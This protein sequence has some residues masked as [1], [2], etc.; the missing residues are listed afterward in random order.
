MNYSKIPKDINKMIVGGQ[1]AGSVLEKLIAKTK[2]GTNVLELED[3]A[4]RLITETGAE[5][6]FKRVKGYHHA[7]CVC[8][9]EEVVHC[10]PTNRVLKD[11]DIVTIDL[12]V[13]YQ[14]FNTDTAWTVA[15]GKASSK[16]KEFLQT[17]QEALKAGV[18]QARAGNHIGDVS[19]AIESVIKDQGYGIVKTLTGHGVGKELHEAPMIPNFGKAGTGLELKESMTIAI[20]PIYTDG[21]P[22]IILEDDDWSIVAPK[23]K[24]AAVF[25][26]SVAIT[27]DGS[28]ILTPN[29]LT[30]S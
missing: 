15:V 26:H 2:V 5:P 8:I 16:V 21:D 6:A 20:E 29:S 19:A 12:G 1:I 11:G 28:Q 17:G 30:V 24:L 10:P 25:E 4:N 22:E 14:G 9:N 3:L 27:K 23:S 18:S 13:Y 7:L